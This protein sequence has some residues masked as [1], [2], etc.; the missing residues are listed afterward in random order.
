MDRND[1]TEHFLLGRVEPC[2]ENSE[3]SVGVAPLDKNTP[4][5]DDDGEVR[6]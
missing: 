1:T 5:S 4:T 6:T 2:E 3:A